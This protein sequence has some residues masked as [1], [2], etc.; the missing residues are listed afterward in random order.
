MP[1]TSEEI[2]S[3]ADKL[4]LQISGGADAAPGKKFW[5]NED[6]AWSPVTPPTKLWNEFSTIPGAGTP[7]EA[8]AAVLANPT[9][10]EKRKVRLTLDITSNSR[11]Y[12]SRA[13]YGDHSSSV[14]ENWI[15]PALIRNAGA[16]SQGYIIRLYHGDPEAGG[17]ELT[18]TYL[19]G[20]DGSPSWEW[21]Y[22][23]GCLKVSTDQRATFAAHYAANGLWVYGY[24]YIG[25]TGGSGSGTFSTE[26][27]T[28]EISQVGH[29]FVQD[30]ILRWDSDTG[31]FAL[32][33]ADTE[34][35]AEVVG[36]VYEVLTPDSFILLYAGYN[37]HW[38]NSGIN[39]RVFFLSA[40]VPGKATEI[41]PTAPNL[42]VKPLLVPDLAHGYFF[43]MRGMKNEPTKLVV[44]EVL[45]EDLTFSPSY[46]GYYIK[47]RYYMYTEPAKPEPEFT[48]VYKDG[49]LLTYGVGWVWGN[50]MTGQVLDLVDNV[51]I[52]DLSPGAL[53]RLEYYESTML[54]EPELKMYRAG[55]GAKNRRITPRF[56]FASQAA[57]YII[58][59]LTQT[60]S[61]DYAA[62]YRKVAG[63]P[64]AQGFVIIPKT[65]SDCVMFKE[66]EWNVSMSPWRMEVYRVNGR[67]SRGTQTG[68][69]K[70]T[71][72]IPFYATPN[73]AWALA[74]VP[75]DLK[76]AAIYEGEFYFRYRNT[77]D[78]TVTNY[79]RRRLS[80]RR[81]GVWQPDPA[82][83]TW[84]GRYYMPKL[85]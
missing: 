32:A 43:N 14:Y 81:L 16:A 82:G 57:W 58:D 83:D 53:Y 68:S 72:M 18:T 38:P 24:R 36:Q 55:G 63:S 40:T 8:D 51:R 6:K 67:K 62:T 42:I 54:Y 33:L 49:V 29:G 56:Y 50:C 35:H 59:S 26:R 10:L 41:Q 22:S 60:G 69:A 84:L 74:P 65:F 17:I 80:L 15:Q 13:T 75:T 27:L 28:R 12:I 78:N 19:G 20:G 47:P 37:D 52:I 23:S 30:D 66:F 34:E 39:D 3:K 73:N 85:L 46:G 64:W 2:Q 9:I 11:Q 48:K 25:P 77:I 76:K 7:A 71:D 1:F 4:S 31:R 61:Y 21:N 79:A 44:R 5:Y 70:S 45:C